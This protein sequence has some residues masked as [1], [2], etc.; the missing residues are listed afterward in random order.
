[1]PKN[2]LAPKPANALV[3]RQSPLDELLTASAKYPQ[4]QDLIGYLHSLRKMPHVNV[5]DIGDES[6]GVFRTNN[7]FGNSLPDVGIIDVGYYSK[8]ATLVHELTHAADRQLEN[9]YYNLKFA[10]TKPDKLSPQEE[11]FVNAYEKLANNM[12]VRYNSPKRYPRKTL[13][14]HLS[15]QWAKENESY[16]ANQAELP[17]WGMASTIEPNRTQEYSAPRHLDP[18]LATE[19]T[20]LMDMANRLQRSYTMP[21][22]R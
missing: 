10:K 17:A 11:Q 6:R 14:N 3:Q 1:M 4:Y 8:P 21:D 19:F 18:T 15:P 20:I 5:K 16:R 2:A 12:D 22:M 13:A 9:Q 7:I